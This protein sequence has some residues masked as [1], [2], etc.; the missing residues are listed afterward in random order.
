MDKIRF[1]LGPNHIFAFISAIYMLETVTLIVSNNTID[2][3]IQ[4]SCICLMGIFYLIKRSG[5]FSNNNVYIFIGLLIILS[6]VASTLRL[7][8]EGVIQA[9]KYLINLAFLFF[10]IEFYR[11]DSLVPSYIVGI[12][13]SIGVIIAVQCIILFLLVFFN[14]PIGMKQVYNS[15]AEIYYRS[16]DFF[17]GYANSIHHSASGNIL[18]AASYFPEPAKLAHF[19]Y[20]PMFFMF[21]KFKKT[22]RYKYFW[23]GSAALLCFILTFSRAGY[24]ALAA[25]IFIYLFLRSK[26]EKPF[27]SKQDI[28]KIIL[29]ICV[30]MVSAVLLLYALDYYSLKNPNSRISSI[31]DRGNNVNT[32][33]TVSLIRTTSNYGRVIEALNKN[34]LGY[35]LGWTLTK[36]QE[37]ILPSAP[38]MWLYSSGYLGIVPVILFFCFV[39]I[40]YCIP[41]I[42]SKNPIKIAAALSFISMYVHDVS[43]GTWMSINNMFALSLLIMLKNRDLEGI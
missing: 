11:K 42:K 29:A 21:G 26:T 24:V 2:N 25:A 12:I 13:D 4:L 33:D 39:G 5:R 20:I 34:P 17:L 6:I 27:T 14:L 9:V 41:C 32:K 40:K 35:G 7:D 43:Y 23:G 10:V 3:L 28:L 18:R 19:M 30:F 8:G 1:K 16:A 38:G 15:R 37:F 31:F 22:K 36:R